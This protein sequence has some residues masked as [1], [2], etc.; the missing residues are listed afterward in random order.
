MGR[1]LALHTKIFRCI[2]DPLAEISLPQA[3]YDDARGGRRFFI[4]Q[5]FSESKAAGS[6]ALCPQWMKI[7]RHTRSY[8][9]DRFQPIAAFEYVRRT[10]LIT[11]QERKSRGSVRPLLP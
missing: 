3:I 8:G 6:S 1:G 10:R 11:G 9:F 2:D 4:D 5:P 7:R